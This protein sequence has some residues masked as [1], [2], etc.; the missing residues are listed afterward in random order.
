MLNVSTA[1]DLA[2]ALLGRAGQ[3]LAKVHSK[4]SRAA[5]PHSGVLSCEKDAV[6]SAK[7][8]LLYYSP[9]PAILPGKNDVIL[10]AFMMPNSCPSSG[11]ASR[12]K[13][14]FL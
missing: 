2:L 4:L 7:S 3:P 13:T 14:A 9:E 10:F 1:G 11:A 6:L 12:R 8:S 5:I